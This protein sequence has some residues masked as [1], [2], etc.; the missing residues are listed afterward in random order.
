MDTTQ[1]GTKLVVCLVVGAVTSLLTA[2]S[3]ETEADRTHVLARVHFNTN[4]SDFELSR[5]FYGKL[6][7][8]TVS[9]FPDTNTVAMARAIGVET[10][11]SYDGR[12]SI[13]FPT[14]TERGRSTVRR[15]Q[16]RPRSV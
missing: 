1:R 13:A 8:E 14:G 12:S 10:P 4:V 16:K 2:C 15:W 6:G 7:F 3:S 9:G 11:T 5:D